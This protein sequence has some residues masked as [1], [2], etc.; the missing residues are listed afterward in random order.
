M[1]TTARMTPL[2]IYRGIKE[3]SAGELET[4]TLLLDSELT[5]ELLVR[6]EESKAALKANKLL[7]PEELF[8]NLDV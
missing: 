3:L 8:A 6:R 7:K 4:L 5:Q 2:E 1:V